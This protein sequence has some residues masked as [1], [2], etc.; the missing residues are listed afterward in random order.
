[1]TALGEMVVEGHVKERGVEMV[2]SSWSRCWHHD[3]NVAWQTSP[4][5]MA[6]PDAPAQVD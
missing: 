4:R 1:M 6:G 5:P 3:V 2:V